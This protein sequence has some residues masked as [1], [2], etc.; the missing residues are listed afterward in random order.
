MALCNSDPAVIKLAN[1][2]MSHFSERPIRY[3]VQYHADQCLSELQTFWGVQVGAPPDAIKL[4][5]KS[6]SNQLRKRTWRSKY[7]VLTVCT[8]D[9]LFRARLD[10]WMDLLRASWN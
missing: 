2:W 5:R 4:Q 9:T 6:N 10:A 3:R 1:H 7:G 8:S